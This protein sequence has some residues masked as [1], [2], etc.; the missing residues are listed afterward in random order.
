V[1][2]S[3]SVGRQ[4]MRVASLIPSFTK[5]K[6]N[7]CREIGRSSSDQGDRENILTHIDI[8]IPDQ[9]KCCLFLSQFQQQKEC[10]NFLCNVLPKHA[11]MGYYFF[12]GSKKVSKDFI[13]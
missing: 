9:E 13:I 1:N 10:F 5:H 2:L 3:P 6:H 7:L 8:R 11:D 12:F 4:E